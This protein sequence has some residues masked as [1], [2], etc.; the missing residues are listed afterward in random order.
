ML[1]P[2]LQQLQVSLDSEQAEAQVRVDAMTVKTDA[3]IENLNRKLSDMRARLESL[4]QEK[5]SALPPDAAK[6]LRELKGRLAKAEGDCDKKEVEK[7]ELSSKIRELIGRQAALE[8][9]QTSVKSHS[10]DAEA[11]LKALR[12]EK[13]REVK[14]LQADA[15]KKERERALQ[16]KKK[17]AALEAK[18][19]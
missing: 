3:E 2:Q 11:R 10:S 1:C 4:E 5:M 12:Q 13:D 9:A 19:S 16:E 17:I 15:D 7:A 18:V 6:E 14:R 8:K